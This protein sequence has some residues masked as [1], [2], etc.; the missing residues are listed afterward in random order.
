MSKPMPNVA[1]IMMSFFLK[2]RDIYRSREEILAEVGIKSGDTVLDF[3]CG[4]GSYTQIAAQMVQ[5]AGKVYAL[6][7]Q[8]LAIKR[9]QKMSQRAGLDNI[10]TICSDGA[11]DLADNSVDVI[12][13]YDVF[14]ILSP[15]D[16]ILAELHRI[17]KPTGFLS[18]SD[19]HLQEKDIFARMTVDGLFELT[20][21][22]KWTYRF[23]KN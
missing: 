2:C 8:P 10:E 14:H 11:T 21:K 20:E 13:L 16:K 15:A 7:Q 17:L 6:D 23:R 5:P 1:F 9:I 19:H 3:G 22:G 18:F 4:P 12:L